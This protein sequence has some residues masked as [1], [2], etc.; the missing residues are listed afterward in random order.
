MKL[1]VVRQLRRKQQ[2]QQQHL[3][4]LANIDSI[5]GTQ[6]ERRQ[7]QQQ[8]TSILT[9]SFHLLKGPVNSHRRNESEDGLPHH[10]Q[11]L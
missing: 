6:L 3:Q 4:Q 1:Q 7:T 10:L 8:T 2:Q 9:C 5:E 11:Q